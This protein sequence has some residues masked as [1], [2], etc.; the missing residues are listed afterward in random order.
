[1]KYEDVVETTNKKDLTLACVVSGKSPRDIVRRM[2][3]PQL[4]RD[5]ELWSKMH[6]EFGKILE[7]EKNIYEKGDYKLTITFDTGKTQKNGLTTKSIRTS[8]LNNEQ[9][10]IEFL[11]SKNKNCLFY[12]SYAE[13][14]KTGGVY[15]QL[16]DYDILD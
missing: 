13:N 5:V 7:V 3:D 15:R 9:V 8:F 16:I 14:K 2:R 6:Y 1:M 11:A 10:Y 4:L 12:V